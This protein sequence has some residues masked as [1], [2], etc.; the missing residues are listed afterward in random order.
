MGRLLTLALLTV[1]VLGVG[2]GDDDGSDPGLDAGLDAG[3][4][5]DSGPRADALFFDPAD[6]VDPAAFEYDWTCTGEVAPDLTAPMA[7]PPV[8]DCSAGIWPDLEVAQ[9]CPTITDATRTDPDTGMPLPPADDRTLPTQIPVSESGSFLPTELPMSWPS[10]LRVVAW[11]MEYSSNLDAQLDTL[12]TDPELASADVYLLSEVDRCSA[13]N[14]VRRAAR[15]LAER[16][17]G[18][19][20]YG[21]E[22]V[23]LSIDRTVGGDTGQAIVSRRPLTGVGLLCHT[24]HNDWFAEDDEPRLGQRVVLYGEVPVGETHARVVALHLESKDAFGE[25]RAVQVKELLD[26]AQAGACERPQV[27]AGDFNAWYPT[28]PEL[29]LMR[30][31]GF[32]DALDEVGDTGFTH[33]GSTRLDYVWT[34]G[35]TAREGAVLREVMTS[36]H[37]PIWVDLELTP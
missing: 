24:A 28:T 12:T 37:F 4:A 20:A 26:A 27:V 22:F 7:E 34:R 16:V 15:M 10:T 5:R 3:T 19:Y 1:P 14:G 11:N 13:R 25:L 17:G 30:N 2:C 36:D 8:E 18:A 31:A 21:I 9:I 35:F 23:E 6:Y 29:V 32:T 33:S